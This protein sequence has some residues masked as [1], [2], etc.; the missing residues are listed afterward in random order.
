MFQHKIMN[1]DRTYNLPSPNNDFRINR[2][3]GWECFD[4]SQVTRYQTCSRFSNSTWYVEDIG[5][6]EEE[7]SDICKNTKPV[8]VKKKK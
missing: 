1:S 4:A 6:E 2:E 7:K 3:I 8:T 5:Y